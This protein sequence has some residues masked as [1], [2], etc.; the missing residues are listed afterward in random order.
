MNYIS[1]KMK[2]PTEQKLQFAND[3]AVI[4]YEFENFKERVKERKSIIDAHEL[5]VSKEKT[6]VL[7]VGKAA[8]ECVY[9]TLD[10][11]QLKQVQSFRYLGSTVNGRNNTECEIKRRK[12]PVLMAWQKLTEI[13]YDKR[14]EGRIKINVF[15][16]CIRFSMLYALETLPNR[17]VDVRR[18][19]HCTTD[20]RAD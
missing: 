6:E 9:V 4:D 19:V 12:Q 16:T 17:I 5:G 10:G 3:L 14:I 18:N 20:C 8:D 13:S 7:A 2:Q 11:F 15:H 1:N